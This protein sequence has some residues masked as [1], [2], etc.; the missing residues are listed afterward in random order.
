MREILFQL[1][2]LLYAVVCF[3]AGP[4]VE[5]DYRTEYAPDPPPPRD[6]LEYRVPVDRPEE[7]W[8][9]KN[10]PL[11]ET[12]ALLQKLTN[13]GYRQY[14]AVRPIASKI[15]FEHPDLERYLAD[16]M[17]KLGEWTRRRYQDG[18]FGLKIRFNPETI[19]HRYISIAGQVPGDA[20][21]RLV[22]PQ[23][24]ALHAKKI[25]ADPPETTPPERARQVLTRLMQERHGGERV[26]MDLE[27]AREWWKKNE[28]RF[29][30]K[31]SA[32]E[33]AKAE[34]KAEPVE[35]GEPVAKRT[36]PVV[37]QTGGKGERKNEVGWWPW[38]AGGGLLILLVA[39][40][41][42]RAKRT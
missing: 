5:A 3:G 19:H 6:I 38:A 31:T 27:E 40:V 36:D 25:N 2:A 8:Q 15:L 18:E 7:V 26:P 11:P 39:V 9:L 1:A 37:A 24:F 21:F 30:V 35:K 42:G 23:L 32:P 16:R 29:A 13:E 14:A 10:R 22:G 12:F 17:E 33:P 20:A 28:H 41:A 4:L 34:E